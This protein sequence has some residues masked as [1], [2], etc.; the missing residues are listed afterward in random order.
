[1]YED[2]PAA[3]AILTQFSELLRL[4]LRTSRAQEI[5][6]DEELQIT[7]L[8]LDLGR[9]TPSLRMTESVRRS[10]TATTPPA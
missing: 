7:R 4:T 10:L 6:L 2:M 5:S 8:Y 3:D 9:T 1:M